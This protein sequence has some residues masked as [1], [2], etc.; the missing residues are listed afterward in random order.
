MEV[1]KRDHLREKK[2]RCI[3]IDLSDLLYSDPDQKELEDAVLRNPKN[4]VDFFWNDIVADIPA[5]PKPA[6]WKSPVTYVIAVLGVLALWYY[7]KRSTK[8]SPQ[9]KQK[10][11]N[12]KK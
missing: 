3:E 10:R 12:K 2:L 4:R 9:R 6:F 7:K 8:K 1:G 5:P 11:F